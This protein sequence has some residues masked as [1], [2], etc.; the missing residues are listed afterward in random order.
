MQLSHNTTSMY[1][2]IV[3]YIGIL[4][5]RKANDKFWNT[6]NKTILVIFARHIKMEEPKKKQPLKCLLRTVMIFWLMGLN[7]AKSKITAAKCNCT[8]TLCKKSEDEERNQLEING[9]RLKGL[10]ISFCS[11]SVVYKGI[12]RERKSVV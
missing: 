3:A 7:K 1:M 11:R 5:C 2:Y 12:E 8:Y 9:S 4:L 6:V 10:L